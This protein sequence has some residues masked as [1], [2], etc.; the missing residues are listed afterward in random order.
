MQDTV[1]LAS[2]FACMG[3]EIRNS[4][5][6]H[7]ILYY[8]AVGMHQQL[9]GPEETKRLTGILEGLQDSQDEDTK[10]NGKPSS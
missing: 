8:C 1:A 9:I 5:G 2:R 3:E 7:W 10:L 4:T 6:R